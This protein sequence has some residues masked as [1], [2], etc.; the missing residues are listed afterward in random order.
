MTPRG[1]ERFSTL[2]GPQQDLFGQ[3]LGSL[4]GK[5]GGEG[6]ERFQAPYLRQYQQ[7]IVP[8]LAERF[9]GAG[10]GA[11]S[12]SAFQQALG[13]SAVDLQERLAALGG[14]QEQ[15]T[16]NQ[17]MQMLGMTT[18]GL[19]QK[20]MPFWQQLLLSMSAGGSEAIGKLAGGAAG[21]A[22]F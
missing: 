3:L 9:S 19:V 12:S 13:G 5:L 18:E 20:P 6:I 1:Y 2:S 15:N 8:G 10:A 22:L 16:L 14:Q 11:Q 7:E 17:L 4:Q 21:A